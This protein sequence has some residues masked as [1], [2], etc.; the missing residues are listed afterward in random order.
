MKKIGMIGVISNPVKSLN[1]HN[2]GWTLA[3]KSILETKF[4]NNVDLLTE[5]ENWDSYDVLVVNEG[6]NYKEGSYN[7]FGGVQESVKERLKKISNFKGELYCINEPI[8]Y[9]DV[10]N[11]RKELESFRGINFKIPTVLKTNNVNDKL[12][13]GDSH[14]VSIYRPGYSISR[15]DGKTLFGF[16]KKGLNTYLDNV[17]ELVF[18][19]GNIDIRFHIDNNG[20]FFAV[21]DLIIELE[22][23]L[24]DLDLEK[25]SMCCLLPIED[26]SRKIPSTGQYKKVNFFG[27][28]ETRAKYVKYFNFR[29]KEMCYRN[30]FECLE[31]YFNYDEELSFDSMESRQS[32]HLRPKSYMFFNELTLETQKTL[33]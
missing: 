31:W 33:F 25:I 6:V 27:S 17:K 2:G 9:N 24:K 1:S 21:D 11:K 5:K 16:L 32:V 12:I 4:N 23:Q 29:L 26:E 20:G 28:R 18:Y 3:C 8:D 22:S 30:G 13:L 10:C 14:S 19:A 7:F 15:N